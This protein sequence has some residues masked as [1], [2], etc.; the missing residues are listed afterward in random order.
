MTKRMSS[1]KVI[2]SIDT[3]RFGFPVAKGVAESVQD[4]KQL[5]ADAKVASA[6]VLFVRVPTFAIEAV[7]VLNAHSALLV[8]TLLN[9]SLDLTNFNE[10]PLEDVQSVRNA[11]PRD[12]QKVESAARLAFAAYA[13]HYAQDPRLPRDRVSEIYPAW[14]NRSCTEDGVAD[15]VLVV[16]RNNEILGFAVL[17]DLGEAGVDGALFGVVPE[18]RRDG[19]FKALLTAS[20]VW[21]KSIGKKRFT[22]S[23]QVT[24]V[25]AQCAI[26]N[27]GFKLWKSDYTFHLWLEA[28]G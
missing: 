11:T 3:Q 2:S 28:N 26:S 1:N 20:L 17:R 10:H 18:A 16:E 13:G 22:Y 25:A 14:A 6:M 5:I 7:H 19:C 24:N 21:A 27:F 8:D 4:V 15:K 9:F 12:A 23:T